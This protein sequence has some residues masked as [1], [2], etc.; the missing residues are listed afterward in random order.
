MERPRPRFL[1]CALVAILAAA[2]YVRTLGFGFVFDDRHLVVGNALLREAWSPLRAFTHHFWYGTRSGTGYYRPLVVASLALNGRILGWGPI[3]FHLVNVLLHAAN[4]ALVFVL[5]RRLGLGD[6][7][8]SLAAALFAVHP[9]ASWA[10]ASIVARVDLL[11]ALFILLAWIS[12]TRADWPRWC[13]ASLTGLFFLCALLCKESAAAFLVVPLIGWLSERK[14]GAASG[15]SS[16]AA[17]G[18]ADRRL[19]VAAAFTAFG[20]YLGLRLL[21]GAGLLLDL[22]RIDPSINPLAYL[23]LPRRILAALALSGRYVLYLLAPVVRFR[24]HAGYAL[25]APPRPFASAWAVISLLLLVAW[26]GAAALLS[27]R[28]DRAAAPLAFSLASFLPTSNLIV[29]IAS[30]YALNFLY[31]PLVGLGL[32]VGEA[33]ERHARAAGETPGEAGSRWSPGAWFAPALVMLLAGLSMREASIWRDDVSLFSSWKRRFRHYATGY[34]HLGAALLAQGDAS[35]AIPPLREALAFG[36]SS[37]DAHYDLG[38]ALARAAMS[39]ED[40]PSSDPEVRHDLEEALT[41][42]RA[43][44]RLAPELVP[45]LVNESK[46]LLMLGRA[47]ESESAARDALRI[48]PAYP[49]ALQNLGAALF[50]QSRYAEAAAVF[51]DL[52]R[53]DPADRNARSHNILSLIESGDFESARRAALAAR[54]AFPDDAWFDFCLAR[55]EARAGREEEA[56]GLLKSALARNPSARAWLAETSDFEAYRDH[57]GFKRLVEP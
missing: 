48:A 1:P 13:R 49:P 8:A 47:A 40:T 19:T 10:V 39:S 56:L 41:E 22:E 6:R 12:S 20:L 16:S 28:R 17:G 11:A 7:P 23:P 24:D 57:P 45:A 50:K 31:L 25:S 44:L 9:A 55:I 43:A 30:L 42:T 4:T 53:L 37:P 35:A 18:A 54:A 26:A 32:A 2:V 15:T 14:S 38:A 36:D 21:A 34:S 29:P 27:L 52:A 3:G 5:G 46:I 33:V 51:G